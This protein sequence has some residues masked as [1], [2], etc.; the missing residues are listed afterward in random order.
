MQTSTHAARASPLPH[1]SP[2]G[3]HEVSDIVIVAPQGH[4]P[5]LISPLRIYPRWGRGRRKL[6][7]GGSRLAPLL[8]HQ[9]A[10]TQE[11]S[12]MYLGQDTRDGGKAAS[13]L[14]APGSR[15]QLSALGFLGP[16][17]QGPGSARAA[18]RRHPR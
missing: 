5:S 9:E 6:K 3:F 8:G 14:Q 16:K 15:L 12:R 4:L 13:G 11:A 2:S 7:L 10:V 1:L 18:T 17:N